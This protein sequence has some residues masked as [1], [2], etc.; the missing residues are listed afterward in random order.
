[1]QEVQTGVQNNNQTGLPASRNQNSEGGFLRMGS[2]TVREEMSSGMDM[3]STCCDVLAEEIPEAT[4][5]GQTF[6]YV[7]RDCKS[8]CEVYESDPHI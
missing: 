7:C 2:S 1:M 4:V 3:R 6:N 5:K 8:F